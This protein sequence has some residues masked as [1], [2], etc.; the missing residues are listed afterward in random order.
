MNGAYLSFRN[1]LNQLGGQWIDA[2]CAEVEREELEELL[3]NFYEF[4]DATIRKLEAHRAA[5]EERRMELT[6]VP[7]DFDPVKPPNYFGGDIMGRGP[8]K[9]F[10]NNIEDR[11]HHFR[12]ALA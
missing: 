11:S 4:I 12:Q 9:Q 3:G 7:R 10:W 2:M 5:I 1:M 8:W 6:V